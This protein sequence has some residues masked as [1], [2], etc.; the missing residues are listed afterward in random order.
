V[1][2]ALGKGFLETVGENTPMGE[3]R[4]AGLATKQG[5]KMDVGYDDVGARD[6]CR[7]IVV[8]GRTILNTQ[9][10]DS[11]SPTRE[12][13]LLRYLSTKGY[14]LGYLLNFASAGRLRFG[15]MGF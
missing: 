6:Y 4:N 10:C 7:D 11:L 12:A 2:N 3:L 9:A 5:E 13:A 1:D 14:P 8:E 15:A